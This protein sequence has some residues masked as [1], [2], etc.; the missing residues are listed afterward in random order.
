M[1]T[2]IATFAVGWSNKEER[3]EETNLECDMLHKSPGLL[4]G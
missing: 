3:K 2:V 1:R 4:T